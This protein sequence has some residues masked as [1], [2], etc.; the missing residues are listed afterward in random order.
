[1]SST[2]TFTGHRSVLTA[3][4][5]PELCLEEDEEYSCALL[6]FT[7]Y[8]SIPNITEKNNKVHFSHK[9][10][11]GGGAGGG[12]GGGGGGG[13]DFLRVIN[14]SSN[15]TPIDLSSLDISSIASGGGGGGDNRLSYE[16]VI[17]PGAYEVRNILEYIKKA[18][19]GLGIKFE[20]TVNEYTQKVTL[21]SCSVDLEFT[22]KDSIHRLL[23]FIDCTIPA[24]TYREAENI[25][26][27]STLN[28]IVIECDLV[29][30]SYLN[31]DKCHTIHQFA[32]QTPHGFK[33]V[34]VPRNIVYLPIRHKR[35]QSIQIRIVDQDGNPIDFCG[36]KIA[37]R[38]HIK[39]I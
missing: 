31:G 29:D 33:I 39:R 8:N 2:I 12:G 26:N 1:M 3:N 18:F 13:D 30:G 36:E 10:S 38:L 9:F 17:P 21:H 6:D 14:D 4:F 23:G 34:E 11:G 24:N 22:G 27:I 28:T 16:L 7:T 15:H 25:V 5:F 35:I 32:L 19:D 20:T 37:C